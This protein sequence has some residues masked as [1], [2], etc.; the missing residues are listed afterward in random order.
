MEIPAMLVLTRKPGESVFIGQSIRVTVLQTTN[1]SR[2]RLGIEAPA[3]VKV[4]REELLFAAVG[5]C[6]PDTAES[7]GRTDRYA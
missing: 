2:I 5:P 3:D 4:L 7:C 1:R 6:E